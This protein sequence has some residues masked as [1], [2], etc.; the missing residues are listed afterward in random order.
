MRNLEKDV[1]CVFWFIPDYY[2]VFKVLK[3]G[4]K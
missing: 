1:Q 3:K 2:S 4:C